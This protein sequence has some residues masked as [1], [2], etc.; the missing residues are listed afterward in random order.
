MTLDA[1]RRALLAALAG[2]PLAACTNYGPPDVPELAPLATSL[3]DTVWS[4]SLG[5]GS[6]NLMPAAM[7][8]RVILADAKGEVVV[9]DAGSG[10]RVSGFET[11]GPIV[12]GIGSD[13]ERHALAT[14]DGVLRVYDSAGKALWQ[15]ALGAEALSTPS[16]GAGL[17]LVRLSNAAIVAYDVQSGVRRWIHNQR[18]VAL[19]LRQ[20]SWAT[21]EPSAVFIGLPAGRVIA[22]AP[23][24]GATLWESGVSLPRG[25]NE[26][27]RIADVLGA[28][29]RVGDQVFALAYQGRLEAMTATTGRTEW[30]K[31]VNGSGGLDADARAVVAIDTRDNVL[32]FG[33]DGTALWTN[34]QLRGRRLGVPRLVDGRVWVGDA[35]GVVHMLD[36]ADGRL[37]GRAIGDGEQ[38]MAPGLA[39]R[40]GDRSLMIFQS[41]G[42]AVFAARA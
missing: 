2:A 31:D 40:A 24:N 4:V 13:G 19:V 33:R 3:T 20:P 10:R 5:S 17:V 18:P 6:A 42:G 22:L 36:G 32:G 30:S 9:L 41:L 11:P 1:R 37:V 14:A 21:I 26:I 25:T 34:G 28:P 27:E 35:A 23:G 29:A 12:A 39:V 7:G 8:E 15:A 16:V 38:V